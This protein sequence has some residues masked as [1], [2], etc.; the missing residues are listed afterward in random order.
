MEST[1]YIWEGKNLYTEDRQFEQKMR[2]AAARIPFY[3][4]DWTNRFESDPGMT[5]LENLIILLMLLDR[6]ME[7]V[8]EA[9]QKKLL[10]LLDIRKQEGK[11]AKVYLLPKTRIEGRKIPAHQKFHTGRLCFE[12]LQ[13]EILMPGKLMKIFQEQNGKFIELEELSPG[14][15]LSAKLFGKNPQKGDALCLLFDF[16]PSDFPKPLYLYATVKSRFPRNPPDGAVDLEFAKARW[17]YSTRAG[18]QEMASEDSTGVFLRSGEIKL[19]LGR[20]AP[21][22]ISIGSDS[23]YIIRCELTSAQYDISPEAVA[24]DGPLLEVYEMDS[25]A[26]SY[27]AR[28]GEK[29]NIPPILGEEVYTWIYEKDA[30]GYHLCKT[31][32]IEK[33]QKVVCIQ[34]ELMPYR[35]LGL[36]YGYD[37]E[38]FD[39]GM[40]GRLLPESLELMAVQKHGIQQAERA[41]FFRLGREDPKEDNPLVFQY[42][43]EK[44]SIQIV[45]PG[46]YTG[47]RLLISA[48]AIYHGKEGNILAHNTFTCTG[49]GMQEAYENPNPGTGGKNPEGFT[50]LKQMLLRQLKTPEAA[51]TAEDYEVL[52]RQVPNLCIHKVHAYAGKKEREVEIAVKPYSEDERPALSKYY[53]Q[54]I[55]RYLEERRLIYTS[56][57]IQSPAYIPVDVWMIVFVKMQYHNC[58]EQIERLLRQELDYINGTGDF[59]ARIE[60]VKLLK[61]I[62]DLPCVEYVR[63]FCLNGEREDLIIPDHGLA[64]AGTIKLEV[65]SNEIV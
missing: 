13:E 60:L 4:R 62:E 19:R 9:I 24:I 34:K 45:D 51:V 28:V 40:L 38:E 23:G 11:S 44:G 49:D 32:D 63:D 56:F 50:E 26:L 53:R 54:C 10:E 12:T 55:E 20:E 61:K 41:A 29:L 18:F 15:P 30:D 46:D 5:I 42:N 39:V 37:Q 64:C 58:S 57:R 33:E 17:S 8:P 3:S 65:K 7:E 2:E 31:R 6:Q 36:L 1:Q 25:K 22:R 48:C 27:T 16:L 35:D 52:V 59:G 43:E 21:E 47:W 14:N